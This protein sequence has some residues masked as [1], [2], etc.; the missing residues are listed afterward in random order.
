MALKTL[1]CCGNASSPEQRSALRAINT[2]N[3]PKK[4]IRKL[5]GLSPNHLK[6][7]R[8][9]QG[10]MWGARGPFPPA[11]AMVVAVVTPVVFCAKATE[12]FNENTKTSFLL[13]IIL[14][15][16]ICCKTYCSSRTTNSSVAQAPDVLCPEPKPRWSNG[17]QHIGYRR[18]TLVICES[19]SYIVLRLKRRNNKENK[20]RLYTTYLQ[21]LIILDFWLF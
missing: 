16:T 15:I 12:K 9:A 21:L 11:A 18:K 20:N 5:G 8:G 6:H 19:D 7:W 3:P 13:T 14:L 2:L 10:L 1:Q 17:P 4:Y